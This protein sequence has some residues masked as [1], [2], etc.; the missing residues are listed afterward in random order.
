MIK[1][2][3]ARYFITMVAIFLIMALA[4][5]LAFMIKTSRET[6]KYG[7]IGFKAASLI[8]A[9]Q[10]AESTLFYIDTASKYAAENAYFLTAYRGAMPSGSECGNH[11]GF[12]VWDFED[13][14]C[15]PFKA[16]PPHTNVVEAF[17][18]MM[19]EELNAFFELNEELR[20]PKDNY[21]INLFEEEGQLVISGDAM[22]PLSFDVAKYYRPVGFTMYTP[23]EIP[24]YPAS[25]GARGK[26]QKV[27]DKYG[28]W[29]KQYSQMYGVQHLEAVFGG[30]IAH[31]SAADPYVIGYAAAE[32]GI[33]QFTC[34]TAKQSRFLEIFGKVTCCGCSGYGPE[35]DIP[36]PRR[37]E[38][39]SWLKCNPEND[40]RFD[41][42]KSVQAMV[43][44][45]Y[46]NYMLYKKMFEEEVGVGNANEETL[47]HCALLAYNRGEGG[48]RSDIRR[49]GGVHA[50]NS[51]GGWQ[52]VANSPR[53]SSRRWG[54]S[55]SI[56]DYAAIYN[57]L[58]TGTPNDQQTG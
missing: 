48:V 58:L 41:E 6:A 34:P 44:Y 13:E 57:E 20:M 31:E 21:H 56:M 55:K 30:Q 5:M 33:A 19:N 2:K 36:C 12:A 18:E 39:G 38:P 4:V 27:Y 28:V 32:V 23:V 37:W 3:K 49:A 17:E 40:G 16:K 50:V 14:N 15:L 43:K 26:V 1:H 22:N 46:D 54:Y 9:Y 7:D 25:K 51:P 8:N 11:Y 29:I 35:P 47:I 10:K 24:S 52:K 45:I 42:Q 53:V